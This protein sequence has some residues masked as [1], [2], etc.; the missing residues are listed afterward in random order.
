[1]ETRSKKD[2][3][4]Q[5]IEEL[6]KEF[7]MCDESIISDSTTNLSV[8]KSCPSDYSEDNY[9]EH[10]YKSEQASEPEYDAESSISMS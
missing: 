1:M 9:S 7:D 10:Y 3:T 6:C 4:K 5:T 2:L 8:S